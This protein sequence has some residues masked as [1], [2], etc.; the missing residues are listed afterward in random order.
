[1]AMAEEARDAAPTMY[2]ADASHPDK[3]L[4]DTSGYDPAVVAQISELMSALG[5]LREAELPA[6]FDLPISVVEVGPIA[7]MHLPVEPFASYAAAIEAG[8]RH[9]VTR[10]IGYT[11]G[12]FGYLAD[13]AAHTV[14][15]Y[16]AQASMFDPTGGDLLVRAAVDLLN[17]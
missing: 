12:Y 3:T 17:G 13:A 9:P 16:E 5:R 6:S 2:H 7:W 15:T 4:I 10:V 11:D 8:S 14:G 1:M